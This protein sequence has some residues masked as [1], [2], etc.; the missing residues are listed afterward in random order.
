MVEEW[1]ATAAAYDATVRLET[2]FERQVAQQP[3][4]EAVSGNG[5]RWTYA[6]LNARANQVARQLIAAGVGAGD[7]VAVAVRRGPG[8]VVAVLGILKA[9]A[10]YVPWDGSAPV[11]RLAA[12]VETLGLT[13]VVSDTAQWSRV[14]A[15]AAAAATLRQGICLDG[16]VPDDSGV[17]GWGPAALD[18]QATANVAARGRPDALAYVI[19][20]SGSTGAPKGVRVT[21]QAV[22][23][24]IE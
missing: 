3:D 18:A 8:Q 11:G 20:T 7:H 15:V 2:L 24:L 9:G 13:T 19:F 1:N 22:V 17:R 5:E 10:A 23:N 21:H 4:A 12:V 16:E 14:A 6:A